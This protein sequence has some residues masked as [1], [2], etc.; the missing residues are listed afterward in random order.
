MHA[1]H[2]VERAHGLRA[3][4]GL[5]VLQDQV[6]DHQPPAARPGRPLGRGRHGRGA[7]GGKA[8]GRLVRSHTGGGP[9]RCLGFGA[10]MR[11]IS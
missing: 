3:G 8:A 7:A 6:G 11:E 2:L 9:P 10:E 1:P 5:E 4:V